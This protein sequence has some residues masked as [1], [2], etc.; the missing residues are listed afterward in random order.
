MRVAAGEFGVFGP[1]AVRVAPEDVDRA[2]LFTPPGGGDQRH[3]AA[4]GHGGAEAGPLDAVAGRET[5]HFGPRAGV[6]FRED[7]DGSC[8]GILG[9]GPHQQGPPGGGQRSAEAFGLVGRVGGRQLCGLLPHAVFPIPMEEVDDAR[10]RL[11]SRFA[12][13]DFLVADGQRSAELLRLYRHGE[14][15]EKKKEDEKSAW[16]VH[17]IRWFEGGIPL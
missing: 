5:S 15:N 14:A 4:E 13:E 7:V 17:G 6:I 16:P 12:D 1:E 2:G 3:V 8:R 11:I 9:V 10:E